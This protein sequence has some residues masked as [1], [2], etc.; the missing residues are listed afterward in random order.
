[1]DLDVIMQAIES[2]GA[3][4]AFGLVV[5]VSFGLVIL[6]A[7]FFLLA[8]RGFF[9]WLAGYSI[10]HVIVSAERKALRQR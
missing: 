1:M 6:M 9:H 8:L 5:I 10:N 2:L 4:I 3:S 7:L